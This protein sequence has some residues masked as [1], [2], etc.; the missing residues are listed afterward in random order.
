M[1]LRSV[2]Q[3]VKDQNWFAI[4]L[5]FFIVVIGVF[6]GIQVSNWNAARGDRVQE[7]QL[8]IRLHE[9]FKE[10][11]AGQERD[12]NFLSQQLADQAV[13]IKSLDACS[14][15][16]NDALAVQRGV[17]SLGFINPPRL[18]RRTI[19]E[20]SA[21]GKTD[22]VTSR[23]LK[24]DLAE[25]V[26]QVEWRKSG[27]DGTARTTEHN[28]YQ[29]D[30]YVRYQLKETYADPFLGSFTGLQFNMSDMCQDQQAAN[31]VSAVSAFTRERQA[32]Y[33]STLELY[34]AFLPMLENELRTRWKIE[35][36]DGAQL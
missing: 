11:I 1:L 10:S 16:Q 7:Q 9:D 28:R 30:K 2:I 31:A 13:L 6:I 20:M 35:L 5:D 17:N 21:A 19:D 4:C 22:I 3:H 27:Y 14:V 8:L 33:Q 32:A 26:S 12:I 23:A 15:S 29:I 18:N 25:I 36:A 34:K 24:A